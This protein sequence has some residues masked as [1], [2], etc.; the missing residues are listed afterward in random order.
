MYVDE[1]EA[2]QGGL[3]IPPLGE[4]YV[5]NKPSHQAYSK[6]IMTCSTFSL[7]TMHLTKSAVHVVSASE[8]GEVGQSTS[9]K[10]VGVLHKVRDQLQSLVSHPLSLSFVLHGTEAMGQCFNHKA[11]G[12][13]ADCD[14]FS[15]LPLTY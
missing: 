10:A 2:P 11:F 8:S 1:F 6:L 13:R 9:E 12:G 7:Y 5:A 3:I 15:P 4:F 14:V